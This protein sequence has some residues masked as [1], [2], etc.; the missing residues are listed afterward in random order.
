MLT[1]DLVRVRKRLGKLT[2]SSLDGKSRA[3]AELLGQVYLRLVSEM[4]GQS[5]GQLQ[6]AFSA[7]D[8]GPRD[9]KLAAGL[10]KLIEDAC[11]FD[12]QLGTDAYRLREQVFLRAAAARRELGASFDRQALLAEVGA[13][14]GLEAD[15]LDTALF[16]DLRSEH[17]LLSAPRFSAGELLAHYEAAQYQAVLL[18]AV[19][20]TA[21][22]QCRSPERYRAL[23]RAL[24]FRRLMHVIHPAEQGYRIEIDGP[25]S[26]FESVT[27]YG[28]QL[29]L[30]F[31]LLCQCDALQLS[32]KLRWGKARE[33]LSF[34]YTHK[35]AG[36][37]E[38]ESLVTPEIEELALAF[39][40]L[41]SPWSV[42]AND[43]LLELPGIGMCV[44]DL[45]FER[46]KQR[47]FLE[48]LGFWSRDAVWKRVELVEAGLPQ[49]IVFAV[50]TR[51]RV[52]EAAVAED[53]GAALYVYKG[54]LN[55]RAL[56]ERIERVS[57]A[58][59]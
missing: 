55:P 11:R 15:S 33:P 26:L 5:F 24:K 40:Q 32:A 34:E 7:V 48:V 20:V 43:E 44:P 54:R 58:G 3:S 27:K 17:R 53:T 19:H 18:R 47:V 9:K 38:S 42:R 30:V 4:V 45:V 28:L 10:Q 6:E 31:P 57:V 56:L 39:A 36:S 8:V 46:G 16:A 13:Q 50:S 21:L 52:S 49:K 29:A 23:F 35:H 37:A 25:F 14:N 2:V 12:E 1:V 51:L 59:G 22:V 41:G